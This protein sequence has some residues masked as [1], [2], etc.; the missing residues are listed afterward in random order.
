MFDFNSLIELKESFAF[1]SYN[2]Y[3]WESVIDYR[4]KQFENLK[5]RKKKKERSQIFIIS[6]GTISRE[7]LELN[8]PLNI[9][10]SFPH[11]TFDVSLLYCHANH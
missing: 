7:Y 6:I 1:E 9:S 10:T 8:E 4:F 5:L 11:T 3:Q 2:L